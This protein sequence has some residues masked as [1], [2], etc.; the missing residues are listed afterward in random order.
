MTLSQTKRKGEK[1]KSVGEERRKRE[2][3]GREEEVGEEEAGVAKSL[4]WGKH[5][6]MKHTCVTDPIKC[7]A[8]VDW[9]CPLYTHFSVCLWVSCDFQSCCFCQP[10]ALISS[11]DTKREK[12][13]SFSFFSHF[14]TC[15]CTHMWP[16]VGGRNHPPIFFGEAKS[17]QSLPTY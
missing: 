8:S 3:R 16:E 1:R 7:V 17:F 6:Q 12:P 15:G 4:L 14:C 13:F 9:L 11:L 5:L 2:R 10:L